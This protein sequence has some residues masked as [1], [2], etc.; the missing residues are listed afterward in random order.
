MTR[1][2]ERVNE[3]LREEISAIVQRQMKDPRLGGL[4][5]ITAVETS[6]DFQHARVFVSVLGT[7]EEHLSSLK[8]L[9]T[10]SGFIRRELRT[11]LSSMRTVPELAFKIDTSIERGAQLT[12]LLNQVARETPEQTG[13]GPA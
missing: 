3:L 9:N 11:R 10:A 4:I 12:E 2:A 5:S 13:D 1:R 6:P 8:T 7:E